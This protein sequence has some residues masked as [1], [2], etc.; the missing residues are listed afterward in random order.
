MTTRIPLHRGKTLHVRMRMRSF[1]AV[2]RQV[3]LTGDDAPEWRGL[4][5]G[6]PFDYATQGIL[7]VARKLP[8]PGRDG[9]SPASMDEL[10]F[11]FEAVLHGGVL[12]RLF[13]R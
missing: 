13:G 1:D 4:D 11:G 7:Y 10:A 5:V 3:G 9:A 12:S 6:S 2:A 8:P